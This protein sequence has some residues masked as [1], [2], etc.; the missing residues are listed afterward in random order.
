MQVD[1]IGKIREGKTQGRSNEIYR[2]RLSV[3]CLDAI[4]N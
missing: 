4:Q 1:G 2:N 3:L